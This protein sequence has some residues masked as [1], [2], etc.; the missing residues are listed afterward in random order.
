[1]CSPA[2]LPHLRFLVCVSKIFGHVRSVGF[3]GNRK[4]SINFGE[5]NGCRSRAGAVRKRKSTLA[6]AVV[7]PRSLPETLQIPT[8]SAHYR[9]IA[10]VWTLCCV[11]LIPQPRKLSGLIGPIASIQRR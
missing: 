9:Q 10:H 11:T 1:M 5:R 3:G 4:A 2:R 6:V 7:R 8:Q